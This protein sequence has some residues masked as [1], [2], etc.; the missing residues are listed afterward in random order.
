MSNLLSYFKSSIGKK[1]IVAVTGLMLILF[2]V[3]HLAGNLIFY[4]GPEAFNK[5][6]KKLSDLRPG[7]YVVEFGLLV[8][9]VVHMTLTASI[10][11]ENIKSRTVN[12]NVKKSS[13]QRSLSTRLMPFTGTILIAFVVWH[14]L[15]F[16]FT[17][18]HGDA[19][20]LQD[21]MSYGLYGVVYNA[22]TD[23]IHSGLYIIAMFS[24]GFHLNHGIQ[25]FAQT[26]GFSSPTYTPLIKNISQ[27][28]AIVITLSFSSIPVYVLIQFL[29]S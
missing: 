11:L 29:S 10:V 14:L 4:L 27:W 23:P 9:F 2:I 19:S 6:A 16:T 7:F 8:V 26:F 15:D 3:G 21:G 25:S 24:L 1:Q 28:T 18:K 5:Y 17:D 13:N 22:F 12:Y 20:V